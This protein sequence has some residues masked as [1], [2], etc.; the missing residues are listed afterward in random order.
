MSPLN[1]AQKL[2]QYEQ[3]EQDTIG[4]MYF[5]YSCIENPIHESASY[6]KECIDVLRQL[7]IELGQIRLIILRLQRD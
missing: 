1:N 2:K 7:E 6:E 5:W 3:W 4:H